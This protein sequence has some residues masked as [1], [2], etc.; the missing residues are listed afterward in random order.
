[1]KNV[2]LYQIAHVMFAENNVM[3]S[4]LANGYTS[5][6]YPSLYNQESTMIV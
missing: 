2:T 3:R 1:M 5:R 4:K 6:T